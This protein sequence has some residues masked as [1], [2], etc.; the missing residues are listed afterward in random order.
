MLQPRKKVMPH[1]RR[2]APRRAPLLAFNI[3]SLRHFLEKASRIRW[4]GFSTAALPP[5][6]RLHATARLARGVAAAR[7]S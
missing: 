2:A 3:N 6:G 7:H 1:S 5:V 4:Q